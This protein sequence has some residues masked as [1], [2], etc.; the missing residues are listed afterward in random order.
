MSLKVGEDTFGTVKEMDNYFDKCQYIKDKF[1]SEKTKEGYL[2]N[3]FNIMNGCCDW[4]SFVNNQQSIPK[5]IKYAQ[6]EMINRMNSLNAESSFSKNIVWSEKIKGLLRN[7]CQFNDP[8][9]NN[10]L[11]VW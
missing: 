8:N 7:Y 3:S 6:F 2:F 4:Y 11:N 5:K 9:N 10:Y 1:D